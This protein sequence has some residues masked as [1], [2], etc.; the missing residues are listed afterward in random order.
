MVRRFLIT[1]ADVSSA[2]S[3]DS[4][5]HILEYGASRLIPLDAAKNI[6]GMSLWGI[7][8]YCTFT[9]YQMLSCLCG[10]TYSQIPM[11]TEKRLNLW[12]VGVGTTHL[13]RCKNGQ[14]PFVLYSCRMS[15]LKTFRFAGSFRLRSCDPRTPDC[16][17][18]Q[19]WPCDLGFSEGV[20][21]KL[22]IS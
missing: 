1:E 12:R 7:F 13:G 17:P 11:F 3:L 2:K 10:I 4:H 18:R 21:I 20:R 14:L 8:A 19:R 22:T 6:N 5:G 15:T 9:T 16:A